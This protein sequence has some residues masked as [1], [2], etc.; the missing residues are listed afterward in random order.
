M[1]ELLLSH[2]FAPCFNLLTRFGGGMNRAASIDVML[3]VAL[4]EEAEAFYDVDLIKLEA[5]K[6]LET[7]SYSEFTFYDANGVKRTGIAVMVG[8]VG[9]RAREAAVLFAKN[10]SPKFVFSIGI[11]GRAGNDAKVGD[12]VVPSMINVFDHRA[13][14][15]DEGVDDYRLVPG[16][17]WLH[18]DRALL[19]LMR[20]KSFADQAAFPSLEKMSRSVNA[21]LSP[22][23]RSSVSDWI[24]EGILARKPQV[25]EGPFAVGTVVNKSRNF[26]EHVLAGTNR[27]YIAIDMES[28]L[29]SDALLALEDRPRFFALRAISDP[30]DKRKKSFDAIQSGLIRKW[31]M[32]NVLLALVALIE[33]SP[34]FDDTRAVPP[35]RPAQINRHYQT[36]Y[37]GQQIGIQPNED[38]LNAR[39]ANLRR[40]TRS[41]TW[42]AAT[43]SDFI[44]RATSSKKGTRF[45]VLGHGGCGKSAFL[46][47]ARR[48]LQE[49]C[50]NAT[51]IFLSMKAL[52][53][54]VEKRQ[55]QNSLKSAIDEDFGLDWSD[56]EKIFVL[57]D[58]LYGDDSERSILRALE[59]IF[60]GQDVTWI[61]AFG[62]D[63]FDLIRITDPDKKS[64]YVYDYSFAAEWELK[65]TQLHD[66]DEARHIVHGIAGSSPGI[67]DI[68]TKTAQVLTTVEN[69]GFRYINHFVISLVMHNETKKAF[70][71]LRTST[72]F[73]L[74][75]I[76]NLVMDADPDALGASGDNA[77]ELT[78]E[79][80]C[81]EALRAHIRELHATSLTTERACIRRFY[82]ENFRHYPRLVQSALVAKAITHLL[83][84]SGRGSD[85]FSQYEI[86]S[87]TF[88]G[89]IFADNVNASVK[90]ILLDQDVEE[91]VMKAAKTLFN[92]YED[93]ALP[94]A[95]YLAGRAQSNKGKAIASEI[96]SEAVGI[97]TLERF[98]SQER[99]FS[100]I[101]SIDQ[102]EKYGRLGRRTLFISLAMSGDAKATDDY[103]ENVLH[104]RVEDLLNQYFHMEYYGDHPSTGFSVELALEE[105][106]VGWSRTRR[107]LLRKISAMLSRKQ[108]LQYDRIAVL[109]YFTIVR[110]R[111]ERGELPDP[112]KTECLSLLREI[113]ESPISLGA[114]LT[115]FLRMM[116]H[117]LQSERFA[118]IDAILDLYSLKDMPRA[119]WAE[120]GFG[121]PE[122]MME[123]VGAHLY[124]TVLLA[125]IVGEATQ[126]P[127]SDGERLHLVE[128]VATHDIGEV[129]I[130]D[131]TPKDGAKKEKEAE[132]VSRIS[133]LSV[134]G[135]LSVLKK[136]E[137]WFEEFE[138]GASRVAVI[139]KD[140]DKLDAMLQAWKY[141]DRFSNDDDRQEFLNYHVERMKT[142]ELRSLAEAIMIRAEEVRM[143]A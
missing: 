128:L 131:Y 31:A 67:A 15:E 87:D 42:E 68:D 111:H 79:D 26:H 61:F 91:G 62:V 84:L 110:T 78:F 46:M 81:V 133:S 63:H 118:T 65:S 38:Q 53:T 11:S 57:L 137:G 103:I 121:D 136:F 86:D 88:F 32:H 132:A 138:S 20:G 124:G 72:E 17:N 107:A 127:L 4:A 95:L 126:P 135:G 122:D 21:E 117:V 116:E 7:F 93:N 125:L 33:R 45:L 99:G 39:F 59:S 98:P 37:P 40:G 13:A 25:K 115:S 54:I 12:V 120:R 108:A 106:Q 55:V 50:K 29:V 43:Y 92:A 134:Y 102:S 1:S 51:C 71:E 24:E 70:R 129:Y 22:D 119:G 44:E 105:R 19:S 140:I 139:A 48:S 60:A 74:A 94:F 14:I 89:L 113:K 130:G 83:Q 69:L 35:L 77:P 18:S 66:K 34:L 76:R 41:D 8:A 5:P 10:F 16:G 56:S 6:K 104:D 114:V 82:E 2:V 23:E 143:L 97:G 28:G 100:D 112:I 52:K 75:A 73:I 85:P 47:S 58:E 9:D 36:D 30:G 109:T 80:V 96:L 49:R 141:R 123:S 3:V 101:S 64:P 27:N 142:P 90:D